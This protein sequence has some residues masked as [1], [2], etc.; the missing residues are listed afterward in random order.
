VAQAGRNDMD[1]HTGEQQGDRVKVPE[2]MQPDVR[3]Q[4][5]GAVL[6]HGGVGR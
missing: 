5:G 3:E 4:P 6:S 2:I 1:R